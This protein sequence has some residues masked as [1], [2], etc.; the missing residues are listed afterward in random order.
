M[1]DHTSFSYFNPLECDL[2]QGLF[3]HLGFPFVRNS[4]PPP[5]FD[6]FMPSG[7]T[8]VVVLMASEDQVSISPTFYVQLLRS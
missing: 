3:Q 1:S 2:I 5:C 7:K 8:I 6:S 4:W